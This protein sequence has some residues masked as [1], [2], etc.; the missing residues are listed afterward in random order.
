LSKGQD[1]I[2]YRKSFKTNWNNLN[3]TVTINKINLKG[4][5]DYF[6]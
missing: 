4:N 3:V 1:I 2:T 6:Y 5:K